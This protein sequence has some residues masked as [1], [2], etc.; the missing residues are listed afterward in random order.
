[1]GSSM[2]HPRPMISLYLCKRALKLP[3]LKIL[4]LI[5]TERMH[6]GTRVTRHQFGQ[7]LN[8]LG[9]ERLT[10]PP[11]PRAK[12][13]GPSCAREWDKSQRTGQ[14]RCWGVSCFRALQV[15][16]RSKLVACPTGFMG[17]ACL[18]P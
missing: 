10:P 9:V 14:L 12:N 1:M 3:S 16:L 8:G 13:H 18:T 7:R 6:H 15:D 4:T 11:S 5:E 2:G 17:C